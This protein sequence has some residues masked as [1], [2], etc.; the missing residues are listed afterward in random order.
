MLFKKYLF[1][2]IATFIFT[3]NLMAHPMPNSILLLD[4]KQNRIAAELKLPLKEMQY[5]VPFDVMNNNNKLISIHYNEIVA[6]LVAHLH[7]KTESGEAWTVEVNEMKLDTTKQEETGLYSEL[8]VKLNLIPPNHA[9]T[10]RFNLY[11]DAIIHQVVTHKILVA[12]RQDF[13]N[14]KV[15][16]EQTEVGII[17]M[18][19]SDNIV[20]P[21]EV[22]LEQG[23]VWK[24]FESM[25]NLGTQHIAEGTDHLLFLI[26]LLLSA[27]MIASNKSWTQYGTIKYSIIRLVKIVTAFTIGHSLTLII[28]ASG[29]IKIPTQPIEV[30]IA[31]S[32][33][34]TAVHALRPIFPGKEIYVAAGFG[35]IHGLAFATVLANLHLETGRMLLGVLG[36]NIGIELMQLFVVLLT[37]PW[38][39]ILSATA[40]YKWVRIAGATI[41]GIASIAWITERVSLKPN[42]ASQIVQQA[43]SHGKYFVLFLACTTIINQIIFKLNTK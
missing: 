24:G 10:R 31:F 29:I 32:I 40:L 22:N 7:L 14:G 35:L 9:N 15:G 38:L 16:E 23:S 19:P 27:P 11:D 8:T 34:V 5:A 3:L 4:V 28:A 6:Y 26:V 39:L 18:N 13:D 20:A 17:Y 33:L 12:V 30:L 43:A 2:F 36:F 25:V 1:L 37:F 41:A 42:F 21:V